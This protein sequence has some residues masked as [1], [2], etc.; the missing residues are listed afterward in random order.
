MAL[1][2]QCV[3]EVGAGA[4]RQRIAEV[5]VAVRV[6]RVSAAAGEGRGADAAAGIDAFAAAER[7]V[8]AEPA[9]CATAAEADAEFVLATAAAAIIYLSKV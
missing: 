3:G 2:A 1:E 6:G 8:R 5:A 4:Q 7:V 9:V